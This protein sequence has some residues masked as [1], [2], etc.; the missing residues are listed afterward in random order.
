M[1]A[2]WPN[3]NSGMIS[4]RQASAEAQHDKATV[5]RAMASIVARRRRL[6]T[7]RRSRLCR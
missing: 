2:I 3:N 6:T 4:A 1:A 7:S 5:N